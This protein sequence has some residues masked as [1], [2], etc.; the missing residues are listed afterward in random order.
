MR[1]CIAAGRLLNAPLRGRLADKLLI[2]KPRGLGTRWLAR[3]WGARSHRLGALALCRS[4]WSAWWSFISHFQRACL[5]RSCALAPVDVFEGVNMT[6][7]QENSSLWLP[8]LE[9]E[10]VFPAFQHISPLASAA[11]VHCIYLLSA[12]LTGSDLNHS[13]GPIKG[14]QIHEARPTVRGP[15]V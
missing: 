14:R 11:Q 15:V 13:A 9:I 10:L 6:A 3:T 12:C 2:C 1:E 4:H 7:L 8:K 5:K